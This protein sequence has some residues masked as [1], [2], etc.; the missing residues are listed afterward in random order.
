MGETKQRIK[1]FQEELDEAKKQNE[2]EV[3][4]AGK[5]LRTGTEYRLK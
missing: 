1:V 3:E 4:K 2:E 5:K